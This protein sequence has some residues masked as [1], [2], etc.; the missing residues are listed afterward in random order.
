MCR[1]KT[2][3]T[4]SGPSYWHYTPMEYVHHNYSPSKCQV[5]LGELNFNGIDFPVK[6]TNVVKFEHQNHD[7]PVNIYGWKAGLYPIHVSKNARA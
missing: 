7:L 5:H 2:T 6:V 3:D 4:L 1:I